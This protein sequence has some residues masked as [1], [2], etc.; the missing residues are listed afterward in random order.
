MEAVNNIKGI[1]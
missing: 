1:Y